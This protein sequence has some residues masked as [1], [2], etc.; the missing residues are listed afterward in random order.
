MSKSILITLNAT[1]AATQKIKNVEKSVTSLG[2]KVR[3][4]SAAQSKSYKQ[5]TASVT[6]LGSSVKSS[7]VTQAKSLED[8][9]NTL[10]AL[11]NRFRYLSLVAGMAAGAMTLLT[12]SFVDAAVEAE[13]A[14]V[15]LGAYAIISGQSFDKANDVALK[16]ARTGLLSVTEASNTLKNLL[17]TG[18][19]IDKAE[20][21]MQGM[22]DT[23]VLSKEI[24][25]DTFGK[26]LEKSSLG[27]R[28]LQERQV[29][30]IGINFRADQVWKAYGKTIDKTTAQMTTADK[31]FAIINYLLQETKKFAGGAEL[32]A[33]TFGG[34]LSALSS[35]LFQT[36]AALGTTLIPVI[37][38]LAEAFT[39]LSDKIREAAYTMP[40]LTMV[41]ISG[42]LAVT[43]LITGLATAGALFPMI[44]KGAQFTVDALK[45]LS[46]SALWT[47]LKFIALAAAIGTTIYLV[48]KAT[49]QW[50]KWTASIKNLQ[51]RIAELMKPVEKLNEEITD[52]KVAK[53]L[54]KIGDQMAL[55]TR[56]FEEGMAKW[57][58]KHDKT[59]KD[60]KKQ[61][62][63]LEREYTRAL[64]KINDNFKD[65]Q[66]DEALSHRRK[67]EDIQ[68]EIDEEI[69]KGLWAD[70]TKIRNLKR[71]L[72]RENEDYALSQKRNEERRDE[73]LKD[74]E[75]KYS[76]R[77]AT[78]KKEL[79]DEEELEKN[80]AADIAKWRM[81]PLLD[82][83]NEQKRQYTERM[84]QLQEQMSEIKGN[85]EKQI[86]LNSDIGNSL[87][88]IG[89][90]IDDNTKKVKTF[91]TKFQ[92]F[93]TNAIGDNTKFI[94]SLGLVGTSIMG[95]ITAIMLVKAA[96][97][98]VMA[99]RIGL[100]FLGLEAT[101]VASLGKVSIAVGTLHAALA[102]IPLLFTITVVLAGFTLIMNQ[103]NQL[104]S[105]L[106]ILD[107]SIESLA[108]T[109]AE[110]IKHLKRLR[111]TG[112]ITQEEYRRRL[113]LI[114]RDAQQVNESVNEV[115]NLFDPGN[116]I[117]AGISGLSNLLGQFPF[118]PQFA[119]GGVVPGSPNQAVPILAHGGETVIPAGESP[120][121]V[122]IYNP[123][124]RNDNDITRIANQVESVLSRR[125]YLKRFA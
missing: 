23:A 27:V 34:A 37:G 53:Q 21:L 60:L 7:S 82:Y 9:T 91:K 95:I 63:D 107:D 116:F 31:Q 41:L 33:G 15:G 48:A 124:V 39:K 19:N 78:L 79:E 106:D 62:N 42:S 114:N 57:V 2:N 103:I 101:A 14:A 77:L 64:N 71:E 70:Q 87:G 86:G 102:S 90:T 120:I 104:K 73:D 123:S 59:V 58:R 35:N 25:T 11:G 36:R 88:D 117:S 13:A 17:A 65:T 28:I 8:Y 119:M 96:L 12:K 45:L 18:L 46:V 32:A 100:W 92:E 80:H 94:E 110:H 24:L 56:N 83:I 40:A 43:L 6:K 61:I 99:V 72:A 108:D 93:I 1:D 16:F 4:S 98:S 55:T 76:E 75:N 84:T 105:E 97:K 121:S 5:S 109:Q 49:G 52:P 20:E 44:A 30:A 38:P 89:D 67:V 26:A 51:K 111:D 66:E 81:L 68:R 3:T 118:M 10:D 74:T 54:K 122:N 113:Q 50:D 112:K 47:S 22:L 69:S 29:D 115:S 85:A 125:T